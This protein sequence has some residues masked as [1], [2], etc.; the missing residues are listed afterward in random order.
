M[1]PC[2][3]GNSYEQSRQRVEPAHVNAMGHFWLRGV[4]SKPK[5]AAPR[6]DECYGPVVE[7]VGLVRVERAQVKTLS[8]NSR[9]QRKTSRHTVEQESVPRRGGVERST[10]AEE[11]GLH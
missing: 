4:V 1:N 5:G 6:D 10:A 3:R 7:S 8:A 2:A 11:V 9:A